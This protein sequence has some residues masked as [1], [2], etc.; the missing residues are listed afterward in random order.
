MSV[1]VLNVLEEGVTAPNFSLQDQNGKRVSLS[2]CKG[3][4]VVLYF[5][6]KD[7]T[8]GCTK[9]ACS[10][11]DQQQLFLNKKIAVLGVSLDAAASHQ[12][13]IQK[14]SLNFSLLCDED[15][16][17][18]RLYGVYKKKT[19]FSKKFWGIERSTFVIN[20]EGKLHK[21]YRKVKV[22]GHAEAI[23]EQVQ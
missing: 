8:P 17:V 21:I 18:S 12:K 3:Q 22:D 14:Y 13:F 6:P 16:K 9:E 23:L 20:P 15:A 11:R 10:F 2:D 7:D 1:Q 5:Y 19:M 4:W